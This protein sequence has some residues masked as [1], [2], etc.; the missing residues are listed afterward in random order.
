MIEKILKLMIDQNDIDMGYYYPIHEIDIYMYGIQYKYNKWT[1]CIWN[2]YQDHMIT[3]IP[4]Q[5]EQ[6]I[7]YILDDNLLKS[8]QE[9]KNEFIKN[10]FKEWNESMDYYNDYIEAFKE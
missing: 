2:D 4:L 8:K 7:K 3:K 5:E 1:L 6:A 10:I 9:K